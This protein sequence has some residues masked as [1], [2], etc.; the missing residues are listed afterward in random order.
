MIEIYTDGSSKGNPG[1]GGYG[2]VMI[3]NNNPQYIKEISKGF[4]FTTNNRMELLAVIESLKMVK[5]R[6]YSINLYSDSKYVIQAINKNWIFKW[7]A[8]N[9]NGVKNEDLWKSLTKMLPSYNINFFWIKS[10]IG[11]QYNER[12]DQLAFEASNKEKKLDI[13][14]YYEYNYIHKK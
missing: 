10:H 3:F 9:Y 2:V 8:Q 13:D 4:R 12:A 5:N 11:N 1:K 7:S 6:N 14:L